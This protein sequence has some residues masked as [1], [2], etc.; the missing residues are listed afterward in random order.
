MIE[1]DRITK[2]KTTALSVIYWGQN[3]HIMDV[4]E[5][6]DGCNW[7]GF[8]LALAINGWTQQSVM[9]LAGSTPS[10][11]TQETTPRQDT[12]VPTGQS[13]NCRFNGREKE[14]A[15]LLERYEDFSSKNMHKRFKRN[16]RSIKRG[17][18][19]SIGIM[20]NMPC[21]SQH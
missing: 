15:I 4:N 8:M 3:I 12:S 16:A 11:P 10:G 1:Q 2:E 9:K 13:Q 5:G 18:G 19:F 20:G 7:D 6:M 17:D 21:N 14:E